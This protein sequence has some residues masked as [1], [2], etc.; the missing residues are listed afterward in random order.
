M[1]SVLIT[2][3]IVSAIVGAAAFAVAGQ[4]A[5]RAA[6][7]GGGIAVV[8]SVLMRRRVQRAGAAAE[9][10]P[11]RSSLTLYLGAVERFV[12]TLV[13]FAL[14]M[15]WLGLAPAPLLVTFAL[16]QLGYVVALRGHDAAA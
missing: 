11:A 14:G 7:Y 2:Q 8:N 1:R 9:Q 12:F 10:T 6:V 16:A 4:P 15:G 5:A 13:A 3:L